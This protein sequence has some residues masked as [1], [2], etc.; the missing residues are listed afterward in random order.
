MLRRDFLNLR[1]GK[2]DEAP[3]GRHDTFEAWPAYPSFEGCIRA[4]EH[5][6]RRF[7]LGLPYGDYRAFNLSW[8]HNGNRRI[9]E[10]W[11]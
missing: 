5:L 1:L 6:S 4:L 9:T 10:I 3:T 8:A 2:T 11:E 7:M